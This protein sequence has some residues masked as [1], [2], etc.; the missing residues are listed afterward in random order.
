MYNCVNLLGPEMCFP[1][2]AHKLRVENLSLAFGARNRFQ[3]LSLELS[4]QSNIGWRVG[5]TTPC[6]LG[7]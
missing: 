1:N 4:I 6:L 5:T 2:N 7:S 3:E